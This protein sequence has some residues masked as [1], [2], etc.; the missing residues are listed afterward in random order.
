[1]NDIFSEKPQVK[2]PH[3]KDSLNSSSP[4]DD[5]ENYEPEHNDLINVD[6]LNGAVQVVYEDVSLTENEFEEEGR[7]STEVDDIYEVMNEDEVPNEITTPNHTSQTS[8]ATNIRSNFSTLI[9]KKRRFQNNSLTVLKELQNERHD[10]GKKKLCL[11]E[12]KLELEIENAQKLNDF[13]ERKIFLE[14]RRV[15]LEKELKEKEIESRERIELAKLAK[16]ERIARL[17]LKLKYKIEIDNAV[18]SEF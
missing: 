14:E 10:L 15:Q 3:I 11:E 16:Q 18:D 17:E 9:P 1:M 5:N 13:E 7:V 8:T 12:R 6:T 4:T 2:V